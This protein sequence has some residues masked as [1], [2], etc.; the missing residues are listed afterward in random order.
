MSHELQNLQ[1]EERARGLCPE[2]HSAACRQPCEFF[3]HGHFYD[4]ET[5]LLAAEVKTTTLVRDAVLN[6]NFWTWINDLGERA[7]EVAA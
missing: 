7:W 2:L 6:V 1:A 3:L 4:W 5:G